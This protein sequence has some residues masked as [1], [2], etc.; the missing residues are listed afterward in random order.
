[1]LRDFDSASIWNILVVCY[2]GV[3]PAAAAYLLWNYS[4]AK[5]SVTATTSSLYVL[6]FLTIAMSMLFLNEMPSTFGLVGGLIA[7]AGAVTVRISAS[8]RQMR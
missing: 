7:L 2:L 4:Q 3:F 5:L 6:P 1:L 8:R